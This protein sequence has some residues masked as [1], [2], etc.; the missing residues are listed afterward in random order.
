M[1]DIDRAIAAAEKEASETAQ[2]LATMTACLHS[3]YTSIASVDSLVSPV[4]SHN[5]SF[6]KRKQSL[7]GS[8]LVARAEIATS[9]PAILGSGLEPMNRISATKYD[10]G[11]LPPPLRP[12]QLPSREP[13]VHG[14][15]Y[16]GSIATRT[17]SAAKTNKTGLAICVVFVVAIVFLERF[18]YSAPP[19][20]LPGSFVI[21]SAG[22][23]I[24]TADTAWMMVSTMAVLMMVPALGLFEAGLLRAKNS[25]S[26]LFQCFAGLALLSTLWFVVGYSLCFS[27]VDYGLYGSPWTHLLLANVDWRTPLPAAPTIPGVLFVAFQG[28]F[29]C[30]TPLLCTGAF[31]ERLRFEAFLLFIVLWS[32]LVYYPVC[33]SIWGGG[34]LSQLGVYDFAGGIVIH[35]AAGVA[36]LI[37]AVRLGPRSGF[38]GLESHALSPHNLPMAATGAGL[39]WTGWFGFNGGS[40]L[41][42]GALA[43]STLLTTH[44]AGATG[45]LAWLILDWCVIGR[46]TF[47]GAINGAL[48]GLAG[49]TPAS[50]FIP[51]SAGLVA[52]LLCG[53]ASYVGCHVFK[54]WLRIDDAL[55]VSSIHGVTGALGALLIGCYASTEITPDGRSASLTQLA[56]EALGV[57]VTA[58][59]SAGG[60]CVVMVA[61]ESVMPTRIDHEEETRGLD[62]SQHGESS[63]LDLTALV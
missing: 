11:L 6:V 58:V 23:S 61:T 55:D 27:P 20:P 14:G 36:S 60:T 34:T 52:G 8:P 28:M 26:V 15:A 47:V 43:S 53:C 59:W 17:A 13:S 50:G 29:A 63:Y 19:P 12:A 35:T 40:A 62:A 4:T 42:V 37:T 21:A 30:I 54:E 3:R 32:V 1:S 33:H 39:L 44:I 16:F 22:L 2:R 45:T 7:P 24:D 5:D 57:L 9:I 31:A 56:I 38:T 51:P 46:P 18:V 41:G 48:S 10:L 49:V 25:V